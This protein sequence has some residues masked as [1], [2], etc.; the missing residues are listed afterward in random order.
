MSTVFEPF[1]DSPPAEERSRFEVFT[2][3]D[4]TVRMFVLATTVW[5]FVGML[6]GALLAL[7]LHFLRATA[8]RLAPLAAARHLTPGYAA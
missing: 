3:D 4:R 2:Y 6:V 7:Q 5:G 8:G 1:A